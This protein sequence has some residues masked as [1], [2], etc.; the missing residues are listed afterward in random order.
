MFP[1][2]GGRLRAPNK[3]SVTS[4]TSAGGAASGPRRRS[5]FAIWTGFVPG[6][7]A[8]SR[9]AI[10]RRSASRWSDSSHPPW[11]FR[12]RP[13]WS[14]RNRV[15]TIRIS[16]GEEGC[17]WNLFAFGQRSPCSSLRSSRAPPGRDVTI[18][19][20]APCRALVGPSRARGPA[21]QL[22]RLRGVLRALLRR[23]GYLEC[24]ERWGGDDGPDDAIENLTDWPILHALGA[25]DSILRMYKKAW[26][27]HLRQYTRRRRRCA[28]RPRRH[29]LQGVPRHVR[30]A[31]QRGGPHRLQP[32]RLSDPRDPK[33]RQRIP[34]T[35]AFT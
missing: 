18:P 33:L 2:W 12:R 9:R 23:T 7:S 26:E 16:M 11:V 4:C 20:D 27:G 6:A 8:P 3:P 14:R 10:R 29:V 34:A 21:G 32:A 25:P 31:P 15:P 19:I 13:S 24:V 5:R 17:R 35:L 30:L 28:V 1:P 22:D